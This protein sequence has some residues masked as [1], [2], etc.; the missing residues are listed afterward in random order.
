[1]DEGKP[2]EG[3]GTVLT[4]SESDDNREEFAAPAAMSQGLLF[5]AILSAM[6]RI[7]WS[8]PGWGVKTCS[9]TSAE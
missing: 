2:V 8:L 4:D 9:S 6:F 3:H 1:M 5:W 7:R